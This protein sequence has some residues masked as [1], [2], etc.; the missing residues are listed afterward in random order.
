MCC[1]THLRTRTFS[2]ASGLKGSESVNARA[3]AST[4]K[5]EH[6]S[7]CNSWRKRDIRQKSRHEISLCL[8]LALLL[9]G[10][11]PTVVTMMTTEGNTN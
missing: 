6:E 5:Q 2:E 1:Q 11:I 4:T 9:L 10:I 3:D 7:H 8:S